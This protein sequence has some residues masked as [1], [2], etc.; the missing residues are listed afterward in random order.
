MGNTRFTPR[1]LPH[2]KLLGEVDVKLAFLKGVGSD[3][4]FHRLKVWPDVLLCNEKDGTGSSEGR[5]KLTLT[6]T[7]PDKGSRKD[8]SAAE[9]AA[10]SSAETQEEERMSLF[11]PQ[12]LL[13]AE[14]DANDPEAV[15]KRQ[16]RV[17]ERAKQRSMQRG[18]TAYSTKK[19]DFQV[20]IKVFEARSLQVTMPVS[21]LTQ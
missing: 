18:N 6:Y 2:P 15:R 4:A 17:Q 14:V 10:A 20:R 8:A 16:E 12:C 7:D 1:A 21:C 3:T 13:P 19:Q 5:V 9:A 11:L